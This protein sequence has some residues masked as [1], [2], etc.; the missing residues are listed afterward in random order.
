[1]AALSSLLGSFSINDGNGNDNP[2]NW[3]F[4]WSE[5]DKRDIRAARTY[6]EVRGIL[7]RTATWNYHIYRFGYNLSIQ[8]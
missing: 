3:E 1:M 7:R 8:P 4:D 6:E 2:I 5:E